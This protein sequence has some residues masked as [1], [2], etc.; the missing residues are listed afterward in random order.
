MSISYKKLWH[1]LI[2][3]DLNKSRLRESGVHSTTLAKMSKNEPVSTDS[4]DKI[5]NFLDCQ[6]SDIM[7]HIKD[8]QEIKSHVQPIK[9]I[10]NSVNSAPTSTSIQEEYTDDIYTD[11]S[12]DD[13]IPASLKVTQEML[14]KYTSHDDYIDSI[15][16]SNE[17]WC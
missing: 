13:D 14:K 3:R 12:I 17:I 2:D 7:E 8:K 11:D 10:N 1:L 15:L 16:S 6:P 4:I 5:C 9:A